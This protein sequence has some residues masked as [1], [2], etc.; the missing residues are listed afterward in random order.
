[1]RSW[2]DYFWP[3]TTVLANKLGITDAGKLAAAEHVLTSAAVRDI[4]DGVIEVPHT[5]DAAHLQ[6]LHQHVFGE[7][8]EWAGEFRQV[9]MSKDGVAFADV[10][11]IPVYLR[12]AERVVKEVPW[13]QLSAEE[14]A[15]QTARVYAN[16]NFAHGFREGNGRVGKL[17]VAQL[18]EKTAYAF[19][20]EAIDPRLWNQQSRFSVPDL[21]EHTPHHHELTPVF[22]RIMIDRPTPSPAVTDVNEAARAA[23]RFATRD[24]PTNPRRAATRPT[25]GQGPSST[26]YRPPAH[27]RRDP[28]RDNGTGSG[29]D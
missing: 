24:H 4:L 13:P 15:D 2:D 29:R 12:D 9:P 27:Y 16:I 17:F 18:A 19:D 7:V 25:T 14:F 5:F 8:Y 11:R 22:A 28:G 6:A 10:N 23:A 26:S 3:G 21:G 1:M 20:F